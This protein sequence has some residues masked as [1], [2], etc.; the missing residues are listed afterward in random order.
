[1]KVKK[2]GNRNNLENFVFRL[3][4]E[5]TKAIHKYL[6]RVL[7]LM[8]ICLT[9]SAKCS[10]VLS[11][12]V[13]VAI[14][15]N[16]NVTTASTANQ[17]MVQVGNGTGNIAMTVY[18]PNQVEILSGESVTWYN[19][20]PVAEPHTVTF[21]L[22]NNAKADLVAPYA[23]P[24][25]ST[26]APLVP[27]SNSEPLL[28][29]DNKAIIAVN[30]RVFNPVVIDSVNKVTPLNQN[31]NYTLTGTEK[32]VNSGWLLP[33]GLEG[34]YPGSGNSFTV[35]FQK[36]GNYGYLCLVHPYMTGSVTVK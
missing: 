17:T 36:A 7:I 31:A 14:M 4:T 15:L 5:S 24:N 30:K 19:P 28:T 35:T 29:P 26:F 1:M 21:V 25:N 32:Y 9:T 13:A 16:P 20:T 3:A 12:L 6:N 33:K 10:V 8:S 34:T 27:N 18:T 11:L 23:I 2:A 22:D